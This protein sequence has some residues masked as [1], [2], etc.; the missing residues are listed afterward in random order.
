[1]R[2]ATEVSMS[3]NAPHRTLDVIANDAFSLDEFE[4]VRD[5]TLASLEIG[6]R[7]Y[8]STPRSIHGD[9]HLTEPAT[10]SDAETQREKQSDLDYNMFALYREAAF[11]TIVHLQHFAELA[12]KDALRQDHELLVVLADN[13][14]EQLHDL[15]HGAQPTEIE[16]LQAI[17][18]STA[19]ARA[20]AL[21]KAGKL[22]AKYAFIVRHR[23]FLEKLSKLRN[24]LWH[25]GTL[26]LRYRALDELVGR[27]ALPFV[28]AAAALAP[29]SKYSS[30]QPK[31]LHCGLEPLPG[32]RNRAR[33]ES[34][35]G[36]EGRVLEGARAG[37]LREPARGRAVVRARQRGEETHRR[38][39]G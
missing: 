23:P 39:D 1:V 37:R 4:G 32:D 25:R 12:V 14:H 11:E 2:W 30:W 31:P 5:Y 8:V 16:N 35:V 24:R 10:D 20:C 29:Y 28:N 19:L 36:V 26:V 33:E 27:F 9:L 38:G 21:I 18:F 3:D 6:L 17:E 22:D 15:L 34:V 13:H 7:A